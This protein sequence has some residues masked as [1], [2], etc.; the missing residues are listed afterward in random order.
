MRTR[1]TILATSTAAALLVAAPLAA[2]ADE[3]LHEDDGYTAFGDPAGLAQHLMDVHDYVDVQCEKIV[4][5][6]EETFTI[7]GVHQSGVR[8]HPVSVS[9]TGRRGHRCDP[10]SEPSTALSKRST[11]DDRFPHYR[12]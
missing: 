5:V 2:F 9:C 12:P 1:R 4:P 6:N 3:R 8:R 7:S 10:S 11:T